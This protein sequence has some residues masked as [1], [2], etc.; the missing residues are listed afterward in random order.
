MVIHMSTLSQF[1][2]QGDSFAG[3]T[4]PGLTSAWGINPTFS[5]REYLATGYLKT[6]TSDYASLAA[7]FKNYVANYNTEQ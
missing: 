7:N 3:E 6:Y 5:G 2:P 4:I 1:L